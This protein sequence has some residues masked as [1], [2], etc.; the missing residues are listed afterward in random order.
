MLNFHCSNRFFNWNNIWA[1]PWSNFDVHFFIYELLMCC[2]VWDFRWICSIGLQVI[3]RF[4]QI[5][6][7]KI[8]YL[9]THV[10][11]FEHKWLR[12]STVKAFQTSYPQWCHRNICYRAVVYLVW[13]TWNLNTLNW[14]PLINDIIHIWMIEASA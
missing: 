2:I 13:S 11:H 4:S 3:V 10:T 14:F 9:C 12:E 5:S 7:I 1:S 8:H 6:Y